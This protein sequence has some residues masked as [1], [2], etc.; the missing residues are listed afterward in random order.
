MST[1]IRAPR[2]LRCGNCGEWIPVG[3]PA[4]VFRG[5]PPATWRS[6]RCGVFACARVAIPENLPAL[7]ARPEPLGPLPL[8]R[9]SADMLPLDFKQRAG[10]ESAEEHIPSTT[11]DKPDHPEDCDA[12]SET[13]RSETDAADRAN[14]VA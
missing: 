4:L 12:R 9:L 8:L 2:S 6:Y 5:R 3:E 13:D 7:P 11:P 14:A 10:G 1:W